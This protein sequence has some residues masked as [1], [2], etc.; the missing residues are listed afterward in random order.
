[1]HQRDLP[2]DVELALQ[3]LE[4]AVPEAHVRPST[5]AR[6]HRGPHGP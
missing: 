2:D 5:E 6:G 1:M 4:E 3:G